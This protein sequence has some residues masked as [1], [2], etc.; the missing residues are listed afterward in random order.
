MF[1]GCS[2][3]TSA[4]TLPATILAQYC[5]ELMFYGCSSLSYVKCLA[6]NI[7]AANCLRS[8]LTNVSATGTFVK[9]A[10]MNDWPRNSSGIP[11]GWTVQNAQ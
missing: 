10:G 2:S 11:E 9:A 4:P 3:L 5:Y 8:W 1:Q 6:T 7:G